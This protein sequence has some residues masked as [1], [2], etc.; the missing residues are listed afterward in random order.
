[1]SSTKQSGS[2]PNEPDRAA[3]RQPAEGGDGA[4]IR[5]PAEVWST[6]IGFWEWYPQRDWLGWLNDWPSRV[7]IP[8]C[9][10]EGHVAQL[11]AVMDP[12]H[13]G[14]VAAAWSDHAQGRRDRYEVEYRV[15]AVDH[16]WRWLAMRA[17]IVERSPEGEPLRLLGAAFDID[18]R[19]RLR[20]DLDRA[21]ERFAAAAALVPAWI[22][23][24]DADNR[25]EFSSRGAG[26]RDALSLVG[27]RIEDTQLGVDAGTL[28]A[29]ISFAAASRA[30]VEYRESDASGREY[31]VRTAPLPTDDAPPGAAVSITD[32][33]ERAAF[34]RDAFALEA[35][36]L[37]VRGKVRRNRGG[38]R[39]AGPPGPCRH[40]GFLP[41]RRG[42]RRAPGRRELRA[43]VRSRACVRH[44]RAARTQ[45]DPA[46]CRTPEHRARSR[47]QRRR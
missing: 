7:G 12:L 45:P 11:Y 19:M 46:R 26:D 2:P 22:L 9:A 33:T 36:Q 44:V 43:P 34:E 16:R 47:A 20:A 30:P 17:R 41:H 23:L 37:A 40:R 5:L 42:R 18:E 6:E 28:A 4:E 3:R 31:E 32:V 25:I 27:R 21:Q 1:M 10:G 38:A 35:R 13:V 14:R 29:R 8:P 39:G 15:R 24:L